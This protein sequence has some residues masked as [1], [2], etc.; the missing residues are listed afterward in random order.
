MRNSRAS[1]RTRGTRSSASTREVFIRPAAI[2]AG[3]ADRRAPRASHAPLRRSS[4][5]LG[6][7]GGAPG[8]RCF[9]NIPDAGNRQDVQHGVL[10]LQ[11]YERVRELARVYPQRPCPDWIKL[12]R[13]IPSSALQLR[14]DGVELDPDAL[15]QGAL[16]QAAPFAQRTKPTSRPRGD[17]MAWCGHLMLLIATHGKS[18]SHLLTVISDQKCVKSIC[19]VIHLLYI[20]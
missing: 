7:R 17:C 14:D 1:W 9:V 12:G 5:Q 16:A 20:M 10:I 18:P 13:N 2:A 6:R 3:R 15:R 11:G 19:I 4:V 8:V